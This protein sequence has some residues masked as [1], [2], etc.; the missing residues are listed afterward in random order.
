MLPPLEELVLRAPCRPLTRD[1][2]KCR[3]AGS[4]LCTPITVTAA[5]ACFGRVRLQCVCSSEAQQEPNGVALTTPLRFAC[6]CSASMRRRVGCKSR[7]RGRG[8]HGDHRGDRGPTPRQDGSD[9]LRARPLPARRTGSTRNERSARLPR[10]PPASRRLVPADAASRA[11]KPSSVR[12]IASNPGRETALR[13][14]RFHPASKTG[15]RPDAARPLRRR[16][17]SRALLHAVASI[18]RLLAG[19]DAGVLRLE[20]LG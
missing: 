4:S 9:R 15:L 3:L 7:V 20:P 16:R 5:D 2:R 1:D 13:G 18:D 19:V 14:S 12:S 17:R 8:G 11:P 6:A 10:L